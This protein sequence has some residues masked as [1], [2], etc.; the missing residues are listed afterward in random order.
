MQKQD[1]QEEQIQ[2]FDEQLEQQLLGSI[3]IQNKVLQQIELELK[4]DSFYYETHKKIFATIKSLLQ[5]NK[6][7]D[8]QTVYYSLIDDNDIQFK[9]NEL[10]KYLSSLITS[11]AGAFST[12]YEI[13]KILNFLLLKRQLSVYNKEIN[14]VIN[15]SSTVN[16]DEQIS[17]LEKQI[18]DI[19]NDRN[20]SQEN[21][22]K[23][24]KYTNILIEKLQKARKSDK[25][26]LG[27]RTGLTDIDNYTGGLQKGDLIIIAA[28]PS[29]GKTAL[30]TT[31]AKNIAEI[32]AKETIAAD[33][34][35]KKTKTK[36]KN[37]DNND[38][39]N[40]NATTDDDNL[41][42]A[43]TN[44]QN[45]LSD[46]NNNDNKT[47]SVAF[48]SLE[49][50]GEQLAARIVSMDSRFN[51]KTIHT[52]RYDVKDEFGTVV[53]SNKKINDAE[54]NKIYQSMQDVSNLPLYIDD[55]PALNISV[56]RSR[57]RYMKNRYNICAI[58][59]DYLQ[60]LRV[61]KNYGGNRVLELAE[62]TGTLKAI[63]KELDI[64]VIALSQLS[65]AVESSDR[66]DKRPQ[67]SDL[68][69][70]GTI[71]QDADIVMLLYREEYYLSRSEPKIIDENDEIQKDN[72]AK[73]L[74]K[75]ENVKNLAEIIVAKNRNGPVGTI[76]LS[77]QKEHMLFS[78]YDKHGNPYQ[79]YGG[80]DNNGNINNGMNNSNNSNNIANYNNNDMSSLNTPNENYCDDYNNTDDSSE[81]PDELKDVFE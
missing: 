18:F 80:S 16:I 59:I 65:R 53:E 77:F 52:G 15:N 30:A 27:V 35:S 49:M 5:R 36:K 37:N 72:H 42:N 56:L 19:T 8:E 75:Y 63:A 62:I 21:Y 81:I 61:S 70:S 66:K 26:I 40:K 3:L 23:L 28:R 73:W 4:E 44:E 68:R 31:I 29:M 78:G 33:K 47:P 17:N 55:T 60:L 9:G 2:L 13:T 38:S 64:P 43:T 51:T 50:S 41:D 32:I 74:K 46:E 71:E 79:N 22:T 20:N 25:T 24:N 39:S 76:L 12:P 69:E 57:A 67:L 34:K 14:D 11:G 54:W 45:D 7:A 1:V 6:Q 58:I 48:F 10:K